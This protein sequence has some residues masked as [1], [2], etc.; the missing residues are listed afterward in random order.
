MRLDYV[1]REVGDYDDLGMRL[2]EL[3]VHVHVDVGVVKGMW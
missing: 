2:V 1:S 3:V